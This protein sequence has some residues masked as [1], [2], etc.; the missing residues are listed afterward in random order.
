M[1]QLG[2]SV[3][4]IP[5]PATGLCREAVPGAEGGCIRGRGQSQGSHLPLSDGQQWG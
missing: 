2:E 1:G 4:S 3:D 5:L